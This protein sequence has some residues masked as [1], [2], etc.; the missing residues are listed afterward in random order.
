VS[1]NVDFSNWLT[2]ESN[3]PTVCATNVALGSYGATAT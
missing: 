3:C 2:N 1:T